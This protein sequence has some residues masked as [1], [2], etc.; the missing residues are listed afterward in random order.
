MSLVFPFTL[1][2]YFQFPTMISQTT[3]VRKIRTPTPKLAKKCEDET[4][5]PEVE[6]CFNEIANDEDFLQRDK[7][8]S[9]QLLQQDS[10]YYG[11]NGLAQ[12]RSHSL[13]NKVK[14]QPIKTVSYPRAPKNSCDSEVSSDVFEFSK[15]SEEVEPSKKRRRIKQPKKRSKPAP[16]PRIKTTPKSRREKVYTVGRRKEEVTTKETSIVSQQCVESA[17][18]RCKMLKIIENL[19][20]INEMA[21]SM[22]TAENTKRNSD[23]VFVKPPPRTRKSM[24]KTMKLYSPEENGWDENL[25]TSST[26]S[27]GI[28]KLNC[29]AISS[30]DSQY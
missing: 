4:F 17:D 26:N 25:V 30:D 16:W 6:N 22:S 15:D 14:V 27:V 13:E 1:A 5:C 28:C 11:K 23:V 8:L 20:K 3:N 2:F 7:Q 29:Y 24:R 12:K 21:V 18:N 19:A 10:T 9:S